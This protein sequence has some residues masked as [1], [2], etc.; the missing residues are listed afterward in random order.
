M[1]PVTDAATITPVFA[2]APH[3][4]SSSAVRLAMH[5]P[6]FLSQ[7][8]IDRSPE[9]E[10]AIAPSALIA[11]PST[12][13]VSPSKKYRSRPVTM[14]NILTAFSPNGVSILVR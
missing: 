4:I 3:V 11:T 9:K 13:D 12:M 8:R 14:S 2:T 1:K 6:Y 7:I 5:T 10:I